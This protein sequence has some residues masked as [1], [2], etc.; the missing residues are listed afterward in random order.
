MLLQT[1]VLLGAHAYAESPER[2]ALSAIYSNSK[3][4]PVVR[5]V[6]IVGPYATVL[7]SGGLMESSPVHEAILVERFSFGWQA[8]DILNVSCRL[9]DHALGARIES[10]LMR[11]MPRPSSNNFR[12]CTGL[13]DA[14]PTADVEKLRPLVDGPLVPYVIVSNG[15]AIAQ[16]YGAGGGMS[17]WQ[18][19]AGRW[20][21]VEGGGGAMGV[22][23]MRRY[24]VPET[25]W[26]KFGIAGIKCH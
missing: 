20:L 24:G 18:K 17:L 3:T 23:E 13:R 22:S 19:R 14:G 6:N 2:A 8:L 21:L 10:M 15:W 7:T 4:A 12:M 11:G 9:H 16:W 1:L 25:D 26:C 5:R